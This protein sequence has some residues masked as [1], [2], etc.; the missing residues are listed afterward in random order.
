MR[1]IQ[2][3]EVSIKLFGIFTKKRKCKHKHVT[4]ASYSM[5]YGPTFICMKCK[6]LLKHQ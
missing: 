6:E 2:I 3:D 4:L 5:Q 1:D